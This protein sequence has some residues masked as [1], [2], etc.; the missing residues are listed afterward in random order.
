MTLCAGTPDALVEALYGGGKASASAGRCD[1]AIARFAQVEREFHDHRFADD[2]R[3]RRAECALEL[4]DEARFGE[5][6]VAMPDDFPRGDMVVEGLFRLAL[7]RMVRGDWA[8]AVA[9]LERAAP[10]AGSERAHGAA[11]RVAYFHARALAVTGDRAG[12]VRELAGVVRDNP[13][14]FYMLAA[15]T[16]LSELDPAAARAALDAARTSEPEGAFTVSDVAA[17]H[18]PGWARATELLR[19]GDLDA[20]RREIAQLGELGDDAGAQLAWAA[21]LAYARVGATRLSFDVPRSRVSDWLGH[22]PTGRWRTA[23][24]LAFPRP[25][26]AIVEREAKRSGIP[27]SLAYAVMREESAFDPDAASGAHAYGLMQLIVPT[28]QMVG[29]KLGITPDEAALRR[30]ETN[31]ALGCRLLGQLR[32]RFASTPALAVAAYNA[33]AGA[34]ERWVARRTTD[35]FDLWVEQIPYEETRKYLKRVLSSEGAYAFLYA[36]DT[37]QAE[38]LLPLRVP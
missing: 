3:L 15:Y 38:M 36:P 18:E 32:A 28:A 6:V 13:F 5:L 26:G 27:A 23:W 10:F 30:P 33:G 11:G 25:F 24:E 14:S 16:R 21:S 9:P 12:A 34:P 20:A 22:W 31:V 29:K 4:G 2:A 7:R 8:G 35:E 17:L 19:Q 37:S 1:E